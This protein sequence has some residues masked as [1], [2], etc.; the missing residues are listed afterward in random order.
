MPQL[1][2][3]KSQKNR[4]R[5]NI[6]L[7]E[8]FAFGVSADLWEIQKIK[9]GDNLSQDEISKLKDDDSIQ[10]VWDKILHFLSFR[11]RSQKEVIIK[12]QNISTKVGITDVEQEG[13]IKRLEKLHYVDDVEFGKWFIEQ[14][15]KVKKGKNLIK[16]ELY[17][18]GL[19]SKLVERLLQE[20]VLA[21]YDEAGAVL[22]KNR[23]RFKDSDKLKM[24]KKMQDL[25]LRRGF[26]WEDVA[27][28]IEN[29]LTKKA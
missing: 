23:W 18:K 7:D 5:L 27:L 26:E 1:T 24:K 28:A 21:G 16:Q 14:R 10:K 19:D 2:A 29:F 13:I 11:P 3:V 12:L 15:T 17:V 6:Y 8:K 25:L 22:E 4:K 20:E 9:L